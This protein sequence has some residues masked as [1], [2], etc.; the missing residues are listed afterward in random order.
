MT[1]SVTRHAPIGTCRDYDRGV[2]LPESSLPEAPPKPGPR[3]SSG[4][5]LNRRTY[6]EQLLVDGLRDGSIA[7]KVAAKYGV[8]TRQVRDD[9]RRVRTRWAGEDE[10]FVNEQRLR[11]LKALE[12]I[13][14]KAEKRGDLATARMARRDIAHLR[15]MGRDFTLRIGGEVKHVHEVKVPGDWL[16]EFRQGLA[17]IGLMGL[18]TPCEVLPAVVE[19]V[20][21]MEERN[22][23]AKVEGDGH[24]A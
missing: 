4:Q 1:S 2:S 12:R 7:L 16:V 11:Q 19:S 6:V 22:G 3:N 24:A 21:V 20:K 10:A 18:P 17:E 5:R 15:G 8:S 9:L 23:H 14:L 13:A